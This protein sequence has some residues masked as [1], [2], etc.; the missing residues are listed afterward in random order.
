V[1]YGALETGFPP[2]H[3]DQILNQ[4]A[5]GS[6]DPGEPGDRFGWALAA[7]DF[8][9]DGFDDLA[10]G[11]P[12]EDGG[13]QDQDDSGAVEIHYGFG[14]GLETVAEQF[15]VEGHGGCWRL[16]VTHYQ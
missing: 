12:F 9:G 13:P 8:N 10:V 2:G 14:S 11:V 3:V 1:R 16:T 5:G 7:C 15:F 6:P 4:L